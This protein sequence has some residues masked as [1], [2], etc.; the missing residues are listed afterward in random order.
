MVQSL[1][2]FLRGRNPKKGKRS[3]FGPPSPAPAFTLALLLPE[4]S[5]TGDDLLD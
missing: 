3:P 4:S 5:A 2:C 1:I